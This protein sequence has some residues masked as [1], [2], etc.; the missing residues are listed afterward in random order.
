MSLYPRSAVTVLGHQ[1]RHSPRA[2]NATLPA[3]QCATPKVVILTC[4][5]ASEA[6]SVSSHL[7]AGTKLLLHQEK[8]NPVDPNAV[9]VLSLHGA[10]A[11]K[12]HCL[13]LG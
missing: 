4:C 8:T 3:A 9:E 1:Q 13:F 6:P 5:V 7:P 10:E 12:Q 11:L 2:R